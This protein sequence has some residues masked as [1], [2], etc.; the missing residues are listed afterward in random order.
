MRAWKKLGVIVMLVAVGAML[1]WAAESKEE[2]TKKLWPKERVEKALKDVEKQKEDGLI[3][4]T[5]YERRKKM[6]QAR[7]KG[8]FKPTTLSETN[9]PLN[10]IQNAGFEEYNK[11]SKRNMS[12]WMWWAGWAWPTKAEY[13]NYWED[14]PEYVKSGKYSARFKCVGKPARV[15]IRTADI[16]VVPGAKEY[17]FT[18]WAKGE[19]ENRLHIAFEAGAR[20]QFMEK[21]GPEWQHIKITGKIGEDAKKFVIWIYSRGGGTIWLDDAKLVPLGVK[22]ED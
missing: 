1:A 12:R 17:E 9:P 11:N 20:G 2:L 4:D 3:S 10:F 5:M 7:L 8:T 14:R 19:G 13:E 16:P 21:V 22:L 6:L 15:G 18:I